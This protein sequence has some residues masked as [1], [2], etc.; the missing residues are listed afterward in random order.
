MTGLSQARAHERRIVRAVTQS[1]CA[2]WQVSIVEVRFPEDEVPTPE[3]PLD[4]VV[5]TD[6]ATIAVEHTLHQTFPDQVQQ[7]LRF[8]PLMELCRG[9]SG[10][11]PGPGRYELSVSAS[12]LQGHRDVDLN[13]LS[14]WIR[15]AAPTLTPG[16]TWHGATNVLRAGPPTLPFSVS[17]LRTEQWEGVPEGTLHL[18]WPIDFEALS[19]ARLRQM[20]SSLQ[21]KLPK[22]EEHRAPGGLTLLIFENQDIQLV[23]ADIVADSIRSVLSDQP[24]LA[25]PDAIVMANVF[26]GSEALTWLKDHEIWHPHLKNLY[27]VPLA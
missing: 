14:A 12:E 2:H 1:V 22:L 23:N 24:D 10:Q 26:G 11:L 13:S 3:R 5:Y 15:T 21:R 9:L 18:R 27:W 8:A 17:L 20:G 7:A 16:R 19:T 4:A 6:G 25:V